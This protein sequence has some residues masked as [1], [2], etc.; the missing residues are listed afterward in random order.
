M[1]EKIIVITG[2]SKGLGKSLAKLCI[3]EGAQVII[4]SRE[5]AELDTTAK[6]IGATSY[7][8]DVTKK[9]Q[10]EALA[11][12][13]LE[14]FGKIDIW[15]NN[16]GTWLPHGPIEDI[17]S[18]KLKKV[19]DVNVFGV[20]YGSQ[21]ALTTMRNQE[22]GGIIANVISTSGLTG[23]AHSAGYAATKWAERG[24]TESLR[25]ECKGTKIRIIAL[26]PG[27]MKTSFFDEK[28]PEEFIA[29][30]SPDSVA[31]EI[32]Q[33]LMKEEPLEE[34]IIKRLNN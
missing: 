2:G 26:Y 25:E 29:F 30:M 8:T 6:E 5:A 28:K 24:F 17:D 10:I 20:L 14:K 9:E 16:A 13:A 33:N 4:S 7:V 22:T 11:A 12:F 19:F 3:A 1:H 21:A 18:E 34:Q 23:R 31:G 15:I 32:V 27:G